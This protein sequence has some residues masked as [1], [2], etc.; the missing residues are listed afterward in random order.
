MAKKA[1][2]TPKQGGSENTGG[3]RIKISVNRRRRRRGQKVGGKNRVIF[4]LLYCF[5]VCL[6]FSLFF[7][8]FAWLLF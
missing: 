4:F 3:K 8:A 5:L 6:N 7:F 2:M 1:E